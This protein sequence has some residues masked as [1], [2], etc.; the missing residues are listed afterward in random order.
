MT[1]PP[2]HPWSAFHKITEPRFGLEDWEL[3]GDLVRQFPGDPQRLALLAF[4]IHGQLAPDLV[5]KASGSPVALPSGG[6]WLTGCPWARAWLSGALTRSL[7]QPIAGSAWEQAGEVVDPLTYPVRRVAIAQ[8]IIELCRFFS[9][10]GRMEVVRRWGIIPVVAPLAK[11]WAP[12]FALPWEKIEATVWLTR[13]PVKAEDN[14]LPAH[15]KFLDQMLREAYGPA[16]RR[17]R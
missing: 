6:P 3:H 1:P 12:V 14:R 16:Q 8:N 7:R 10:L 9:H 17:A 2:D 5:V 4:D 11:N 15:R 13:L